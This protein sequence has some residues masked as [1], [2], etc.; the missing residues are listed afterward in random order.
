[1]DAGDYEMVHGRPPPQDLVPAKPA[2]PAIPLGVVPPMAG[3]SPQPR[4]GPSPLR[5][6]LDAVRP[7][8]PQAEP[9]PAATIP[10]EPMQL[11]VPPMPDAVAERAAPAASPPPP[12]PVAPR[13][14]P[15]PA[16]LQVAAVMGCWVV[17]PGDTLPGLARDRDEL[18]R[19]VL[20]WVDTL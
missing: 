6:L 16:V 4:P 1:M 2:R 15:I 14:Q 9:W 8:P 10:T 13:L 17:A 5:M 12:P 20:A 7:R 19:L 18:R 3:L 11:E